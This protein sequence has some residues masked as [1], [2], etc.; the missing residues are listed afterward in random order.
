MPDCTSSIAASAVAL[1]AA[2]AANPVSLANDPQV[3]DLRVLAKNFENNP[4]KVRKFAL[5]FLESA[6]Q[7][8]VDVDAALAREDLPLLKA[9]GHRNKSS[10][11]SVGA[12]GLAQLWQALEQ[13]QEN[14]NVEQAREIVCQLQP[15]LA[16]IETHIAAS[17]D[18][19]DGPIA[20]CSFLKTALNKTP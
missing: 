1:S 13:M 10:A 11:S 20:G 2:T 8:I 5:R 14:G 15:L 7:S 4:E 6:Q 17:F 3:I 12:L 16:Q 19:R 18:H 9:L